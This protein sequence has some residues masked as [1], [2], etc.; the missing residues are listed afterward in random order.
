MHVRFDEGADG[1]A[2][3]ALWLEDWTV[4]ALDRRPDLTIADATYDRDIEVCPK[5]GVV[6]RLYRHGTKTV[7]YRDIPTFGHPLVIQAEVNR[8]RCRE[9]GSTSMQELPAMDGQRR[10]TKR[11]VEYVV[12]QGIDQTYSA[13]ARHIDVDEKTVRNMCEEHV[14]RIVEESLRVAPIIL[15]MDELTIRKRKRTVFV[16]VSGRRLLDM[17]DS[18]SL[19]AVSRWVSLMPNRERVRIVTIDMW[20][21]Y[22]DVAAALLPNAVVVADK[23]HVVKKAN[24]ALDKVRGRFRKGAKGK[25]AKNPRRGRIILHIKPEKLS[26]MK[27][28]LLEGLLANNP[29]IKDAWECKEAFYAIWKGQPDRAEAERRFDEWKANIPATVKQEDEFGDLAKTVDNWRTEV[30]N[31]FD[32]PF[33]NAYTES[34][35]RITKDFNRAGRGYTFERIRAKALLKQPITSKP[36]LLCENC[37]GVFP[38]P[39]ILERHIRPMTAGNRGTNSMMLCPSC[40]VRVHAAERLLHDVTSTP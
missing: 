6:G 31:Y 40:H 8:Y 5:C 1:M 37:L 3:N 18:M 4:N 22:R 24:E 25:L 23:W 36:L 26:P 9:C 30:F 10:M 15:G 27:R 2:N 28:M 11:L 16:D 35:N 17:I 14:Q 34:L 38:Q 33:T 19:A 39:M 21:S 29:L 32:H 7:K 20:G 12:N 13:V